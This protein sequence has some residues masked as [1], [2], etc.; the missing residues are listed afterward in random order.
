M[1]NQKKIFIERLTGGTSYV[2]R[3]QGVT[4]PVAAAHTQA[5]AIEKAQK[6]NPTEL[7]VERV[8]DTKIGGRDKWR[9]P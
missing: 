4:K 1:S 9:K 3:Q 8:R 2:A 6:L 7:L 5:K